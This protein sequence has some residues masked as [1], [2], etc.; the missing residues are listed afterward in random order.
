MT[1]KLT[2]PTGK[3][4]ELQ[5]IRSSAA[6]QGKYQSE[7]NALVSD[8]TSNYMYWLKANWRKESK[9]AQDKRHAANLKTILAKL[10]KKW[11]KRFD[12]MADE[13]AR[14]FVDG[15]TKHSRLAMMAALKKAG[16]TVDLKLTEP[17][18]D[19]MTESI[20]ENVALI[21]SI[22][23][24]YHT[25]IEKQV[26]RTVAAGGDLSSMVEMLKKTYGVTQRRASF[27]ALDQTNKV[28]AQ[29]E[30]VRRQELGITHAIW[31]HSHA[32]KVPRPSHVKA[33][34]EVFE[35]AKGLYLDGKWVLPSEEI[36]C[37]CT[38]KSIIKGF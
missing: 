20:A 37:R 16:F 15:S 2:S 27:I 9:L 25:A 35:V 11:S 21:K 10:G 36:N 4:I 3:P 32:G 34:G 30:S 8:M 17:V 38:S 22:G 33:H 13:I 18:R 1:K 6:V 19:A 5:P 14:L 24:E 26:F 31:M 28:R 29:M 12:K 23:A 7:L